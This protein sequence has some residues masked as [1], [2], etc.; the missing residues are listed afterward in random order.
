VFNSKEQAGIPSPYL[1]IEYGRGVGGI[2]APID[3]LNIL[4][5][6]IALVGLIGAISTIFV[7][8]KKRK[9]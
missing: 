7:M 8:V 1:E 9:D 3:K 4:A 6:Y 5:P 2:Y